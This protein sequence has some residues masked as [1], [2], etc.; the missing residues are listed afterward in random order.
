MACGSGYLP[1]SA[2]LRKKSAAGLYETY[3]LMSAQTYLP[4]YDTTFGGAQDQNIV[5]K[6]NTSYPLLERHG[7]LLVALYS[8]VHVN[9]RFI[10]LG[11]KDMCIGNGETVARHGTLLE[12]ARGRMARVQC[13]LVYTDIFGD[14]RVVGNGGPRDGGKVL[15]GQHVIGTGW[16]TVRYGVCEWR[17]SGLWV[18]IQHRASEPSSSQNSIGGR[19]FF[20]KANRLDQV[21]SEVAR[22]GICGMNRPS[23]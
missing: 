6:G 8:A 14:G 19:E 12:G 3:I 18:T 5:A 17:K 1:P 7:R 11:R 16:T 9:R 23:R 4:Q 22:P 2:N 21:R 20:L 10:I 15:F 13:M